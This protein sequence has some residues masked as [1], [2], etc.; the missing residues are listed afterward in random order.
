MKNYF[1]LISI[2]FV[3][4]GCATVPPS[5]PNAVVEGGG[6]IGKSTARQKMPGIYH[7]VEKGQTL[8]R[9]AKIYDISIDQIVKANRIPDATQISVGQLLFIPKTDAQKPIEMVS[10]E[11]FDKSDFIWPVKGKTISFYGSK[12]DGILNKGID[13]SVREGSNV[14][15][16]RSGK[17][18]FCDSKLKGYG[19]TVIIDHLDSFSTLYAH[20][21]VVLVKLGEQVKQGQVIAKVG[22]SGRAKK[23]CLHFEIRKGDKARN[24]FYY[25]PR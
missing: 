9:V 2:I 16:S 20:N 8:W 3:L 6:Y 4:S 18:V 14:V 21:S 1:I 12:K 23:S 19:Q 13:I 25:L 17:V 24:P 7:K 15:A 5:E 11:L 10:S 22:T